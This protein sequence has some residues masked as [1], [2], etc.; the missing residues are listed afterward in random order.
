MRYVELNNKN[1]IPVVGYG[2]AILLTYRY[3]KNKGILTKAKY[4]IKNIFFDHKQIKRDFTGSR[5]LRYLMKSSMVLIDTARAYG[6]SEYL[7]GENLR[8]N[9][10]EQVFL[11]TKVSNKSQLEGNVE[12]EFYNSLS[13]LNV[14]YVDLLL[15]HWPV[16]DKFIETWNLMEKLYEQGLCKAIGVCNFNEHH[17]ELLI[18]HC[19]IIPMVNQI[20]C[21]PLL[22]QTDLR[23][24][25]N[26]KGIKVMAYTP[27]ARMDERLLKTCLVEIA[28][29]YNKS[30]T[31]IILRWHVQIGNIPIVN[32][33]SIKHLNEN[34]DIFNFELS[35]SEINKINLININSRL[36]YDPDNCDFTKL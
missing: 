18:N 31:Q 26:I 1:K 32:T 11:V 17:L 12:Q 15:M 14:E 4:W 30:I 34:F 16:K 33:S 13:E 9:N 6:G 36:R 19:R 28:H 21:H 25:C 8:R 20:E 10:R 27:T 24:Y 3:K 22:T 23:H 5:I 29:H 2:T 35:D 7:V